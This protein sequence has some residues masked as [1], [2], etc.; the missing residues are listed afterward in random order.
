MP[1]SEIELSETW[2]QFLLARRRMKLSLSDVVTTMAASNVSSV[3]ILDLY[4]KLIQQKASFEAMRDAT[5][6][7]QFVKNMFGNQALDIG[8]DFNAM[9]GG[10]QDAIDWIA[11]NFPKS[12]DGTLAHAT[13][14]ATGVNYTPFT[15]AQTSG[16]RTELTAIL[17]A[18]G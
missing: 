13:I 15:P 16:L 6:L 2:N 18:A 12:D 9:T 7:G 4:E 10:M 1:M 17:T 3:A 11:N 8:A 5:G 14:D